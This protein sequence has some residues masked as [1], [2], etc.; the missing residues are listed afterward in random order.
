MC[1]QRTDTLF[2]A[3]L[4]WKGKQSREKHCFHPHS[5]SVDFGFLL[6]CFLLSGVILNKGTQLSYAA[7]ED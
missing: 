5:L 4:E 2:S 1:Q 3:E 6:R 7:G